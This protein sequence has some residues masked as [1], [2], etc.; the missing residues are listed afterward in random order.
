[1]SCFLFFSPFVM[2]A[3]L[4][5]G[6]GQEVRDLGRPLLMLLQGK[7]QLSREEVEDLK[8]LDLAKEGQEAGRR[9]TRGW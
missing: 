6:R 8:Y 5:C 4:A 3:D 2:A 7:D 1:M 9:A